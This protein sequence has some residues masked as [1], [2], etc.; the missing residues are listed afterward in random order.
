MLDNDLA[1]LYQT[2][3]KFIN[4]AVKRNP[5][6]F[7]KEFMF[8]LTEEEWDNLKYQIGTSSEH[9][10]RRILPFVFSEHGVTMLSA[11]LNTKWLFYN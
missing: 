3:T 11:V 1:I 7:P 9:G 10:G 2:E 8:Q 5:L 4:R 6:R